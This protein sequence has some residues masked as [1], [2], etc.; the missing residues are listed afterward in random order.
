MSYS[1]WISESQLKNITKYKKIIFWGKSFWI[2]KTLPLISGK[3]EFIVD[4]N[5]NNHNTIFQGIKIFSEK[6]LKTIN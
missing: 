2:D 5:K 6:K 4:V 1:K 3:I